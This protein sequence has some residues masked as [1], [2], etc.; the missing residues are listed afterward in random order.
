MGSS[1]PCKDAW[2][3]ARDRYTEDLSDEEKVLYQRALPESLFYY[4]SAAEKLHASSSASLKVMKK[5]EPLIAAIQQ[6]G[7]ALDVFSN[8][9]PLVMSPLWGS[10]RVLLHVAREFGKYFERIVEML[11]RI[12]DVLPRFRVYEN[13]FPSHERLVQALSFAY[14]DIIVFCTKSKAVFRHGRR[15]SL[16]NLSIAFR[17]SWKPFERQFGHQIDIFRTHLTN[18]EKEAGLSHMIEAADSRAIVL[19]NQKQLEKANKESDHR[20]IIAAI[21]SVNNDSK[22]RKLQDLR[23]S[24]TGDWIFR[25]EAFRKWKN[26]AGSSS[27][28]CH[29]IPGCGKTVLAST[30]IDELQRTARSSQKP[31]IVYYYCD[32]ADQ[33]TL[34]ADRILGTLLKQFFF[35]G[36]IPKEIEVQIPPGYGDGAEMLGVSELMDLVRTATM[37]SSASFIIIDGLDECEKEPRQQ[38][39]GFLGR[40]SG[41]ESVSLKTLVLCREE[42]ELLRSLKGFSRIRITPSALESDIKSFVTGSVSSRIQSAS[43]RIRNQSLEQD[44]VLEL[45]SKAHG[46]FLWVSFQLDELCEAP[47]DT[48]IRETLRNLPEGLIETYERILRKITKNP[49]KMKMAQKIFKWTA[50]AQRPMKIEE[51]Q[52]AVAFESSDKAWDVDKIPDEDL[53]IESCRGLVVRN[54]EDRT[55][56]FAHHT[57]RQYLISELAEKW[58]KCLG[59]TIQEAELFVGRMCLTYLSFTDFDT[60]IELRTDHAKVER[61]PDVLQSGATL[62]IPNLLGVRDCLFDLPYRLLGGSSST[63]GTNIDFGKYLKPLPIT[64]DI[65]PSLELLEKFHLLGYIIDYWMFYT[66]EFDQ[67]SPEL[68]QKLQSIAKYKTLPFEFRPWGFNQ[69]HGPYGCVSCAHVGTSGPAATQLPFMSLFHYAAKV[70]H[71]PLME[72]LIKDYCSHERGDDETLVIAC[73]N[74][75][76]SIVERLMRNHGF[77]ISNGKA[78]N[79]AAASGHEKVLTLLLDQ[80]VIP[81]KASRTTPAYFAYSVERNGHVPLSLGA[82]NAHEAI[83]EILYERG[84]RVNAEVDRSGRSALSA[85]ANNGH[86]HLVRNLLAKRAKILGT[87]TTALHC[88]AENGHD[89]VVRILLQVNA[90][91]NSQE[92]L[93]I[94]P[95]VLQPHF[96]VG[97]LDWEGETPLH[98]A[99]RNGHRLVVEALLELDSIMRDWITATTK[100]RATYGFTAIHLAASNGHVN[101]LAILARQVS[102]DSRTFSGQTPLLVAAAAGRVPPIHWLVQNGANTHVRDEDGY[103]AMELAAVNSREEA[104]HALI[105]LDQSITCTSLVLA[106]RKRHKAVLATLVEASRRDPREG[107]PWDGPLLEAIWTALAEKQTEA[108][109]LLR[110]FLWHANSSLP[111]GRKS[112]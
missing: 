92:G 39:I 19:A 109:Q 94:P 81:S 58:D 6:Y 84:A 66:R 70:A 23:Y 105:E 87:G 49:M 108:E 18:V 35:G 9:Y 103:N 98:K 82:A 83:V 26:A 13:L 97:V 38:M 47:S 95:N 112:S 11:A 85:A 25:H 1:L 2:T 53:M 55:V 86:E 61:P 27:L 4:A 3:R 24:G 29:G 75:H 72:P 30:I 57:V 37:L 34:Q 10:I 110:D 89:V 54:G 59:C 62:W 78:I 40:I 74:G 60:Q 15:S 91:Y 43:L 107:L 33:R 42:D 102:T 63:R 20:R 111:Y 80:N 101:V 41:L 22:H 31:H 96:L 36:C 93:N 68:Y 46:M 64:K 51:V 67:S 100:A 28:C 99:A 14:V 21:P 16:T 7:Q 17:L 50:C 104:V 12:G 65:T 79:A 52:E 77:D 44:I 88:A 5:L 45:V 69:H 56:R 48:I 90:H 32:Y 106:A 8:A 71:W 73:R 76:R